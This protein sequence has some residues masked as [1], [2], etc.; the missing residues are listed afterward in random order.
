VLIYKRRIKR[1]MALIAPVPRGIFK[2][3]LLRAHRAAKQ[4]SCRSKQGTI[5]LRELYKVEM[6]GN[7][8]SGKLDAIH[9]N[10]ADFREIPPFQQDMAAILTNMDEVKRALYSIRWAAKKTQEMSKTFR[11]RMRYYK[12]LRKTTEARKKYEARI[13]SIMKKVELDM[14]ILETARKKLERMP[15]IREM[16][17]VL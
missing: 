13:E 17:T 12:D 14:A 8:L 2:T 15:K 11:K 4:L 7:I 3:A 16:P 9:Q 10:T 5:K 6:L 1:V